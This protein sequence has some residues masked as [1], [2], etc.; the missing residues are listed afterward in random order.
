MWQCLRFS[1]D[2]MLEAEMLLVSIS[3]VWHRGGGG[4]RLQGAADNRDRAQQLTI[5]HRGL[6]Q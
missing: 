3:T 1:L 5:M 2:E 4:G 6:A